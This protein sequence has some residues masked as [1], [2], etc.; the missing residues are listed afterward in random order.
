MQM[1]SEGIETLLN[2]F[3]ILHFSIFEMEYKYYV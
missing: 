2:F 1:V 3:T